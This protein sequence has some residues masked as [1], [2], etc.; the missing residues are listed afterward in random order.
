MDSLA[1]EREV[2]KRPR[3][4]PPTPKP[5]N[6]K[7]SGSGA[8]LLLSALDDDDEQHHL[9]G[10]VGAVGR[11]ADGAELWAG[12]KAGGG[13]QRMS[14]GAAR[15]VRG[16]VGAHGK[17]RTSGKAEKQTKDYDFG[18]RMCLDDDDGSNPPD[19]LNDHGG[20][21]STSHSCYGKSRA[22]RGGDN[23]RLKMSSESQRNSEMRNLAASAWS[24]E[25]RRWAD[26]R[27]LPACDPGSEGANRSG[28]CEDDGGQLMTELM[29]PAHAIYGHMDMSE[30]Q[31]LE[32]VDLMFSNNDDGATGTED[33]DEAL[34][35]RRTYETVYNPQARKKA[36]ECLAGSASK[37]GSKTNEGSPSPSS[38]STN[39]STNGS[40]STNGTSMQGGSS[41][42]SCRSHARAHG[43]VY[44]KTVA[45]SMSSG[46]ASAAT[47][48]VRAATGGPAGMLSR[49]AGQG[50]GHA[51][52][53]GKDG[54]RVAE[55]EVCDIS[56]ERSQ[57]NRSPYG[58]GMGESGG[59]A[60]IVEGR[61]GESKH[62][63]EGATGGNGEENM[64][65]SDA[66]CGIPTSSS[67]PGCVCLCR[68]SMCLH[69]SS[70][71]VYGNSCGAASGIDGFSLSLAQS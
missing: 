4:G 21:F 44:D 50:K 32:N 38:T 17:I 7:A 61:G 18:E 70:S 42:A 3:K 27:Y 39:G 24:D 52:A 23:S 20:S 66:L 41:S 48:Y 5:P 13:R 43:S 37:S 40:T 15:R 8:S 57:H 49:L 51:L 53:G 25:Q 45:G 68:W 9:S 1:N 11:G 12:G 22:S 69:C 64:L 59:V 14:V 36:L 19:F 65:N 46:Q 63:G 62:V 26:D 47:A 31:E 16:Q 56:R 28:M 34:W 30:L 60:K 2:A 71:I 10:G 58:G 54:A 35:L 6:S 33:F 55:D 29:G 67:S